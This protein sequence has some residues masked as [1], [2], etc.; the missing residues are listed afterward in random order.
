MSFLYQS[1]RDLAALRRLPYSTAQRRLLLRTYLKYWLWF[2]TGLATLFPTRTL[3]IACWRIY[4]DSGAQLWFLFREVFIHGDYFFKTAEGAPVIYDVGANIGM[5]TFYFKWLYP[6]AH[7]HAFEPNPAAFKLLEKNVAVNQLKGVDLHA[8]ALSDTPGTLTLHVNPV[9]GGMLTASVFARNNTPTSVEVP[10]EILSQYLHSK[11]ADFLKMDVEGAEVAIA[12]D[13]NA[14]NSWQH[15]KECVIEYHHHIS[16]ASPQI[17]AFLESM[18]RAGFD[19]QLH[20]HGTVM[21]AVLAFQ[22]ILVR[23]QQ[24]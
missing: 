7:I 19:Y 20:T 5:A 11:P 17:G 21:P 4:G 3:K 23:A 22:D 6:E 12:R 10:T 14:Q 18:E 15:I 2:A 9:Y 1:L 8:C 13:L 24:R 16:P